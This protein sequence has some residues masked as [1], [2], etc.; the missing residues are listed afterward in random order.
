MQANRHHGGVGFSLGVQ[1]VKAILE[2]LE[3]MLASIEPCGEAK[4]ISLASSV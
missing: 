2:V 3:E 1:H 4:R